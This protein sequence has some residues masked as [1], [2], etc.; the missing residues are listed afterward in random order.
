MSSNT[1]DELIE[2]RNKLREYLHQVAEQKAQV[3]VFIKRKG[4][5]E[6]LYVFLHIYL[7][8]VIKC[9]HDKTIF[10]CVFLV[11]VLIVRQ[12]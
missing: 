2:Q 5:C 1:V 9:F 12:L 10:S 4:K 11:R 7:I 8:S 6:T 3:E